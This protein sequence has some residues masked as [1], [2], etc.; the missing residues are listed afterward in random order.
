MACDVYPYVAMWTDLDTIL[1]DDVRDGGVDA[2]LARLRDPRTATAVTLALKLRFSDTEWHDILVTDVESERNAGLAGM[3]IDEI[4][5]DRRV[6]APRAAVDLLVEERLGVQCAFFAMDEE[7]VASVLSASFCAVASDASARGFSGVTAYG[8]P[9]P[10]AFGC[11]P[12]VYRRFVRARKTLTIEEA[13]RLM[14]SLPAS[15]FNLRRR[16]VIAENAYADLVVFDPKTIGDRATYE[17]PF[18]PPEGISH[19]FVNGTPVVRDGIA[20][21]ERPGRV[22]RGGGT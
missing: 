13:V 21:A 8:V 7:D 11:F 10:R 17:Q 22:L 12:R 3:R 2:T 4:A 9:H 6:S 20:T 18:V 15:L 5:R 16:G 1:P 14:T 19:V